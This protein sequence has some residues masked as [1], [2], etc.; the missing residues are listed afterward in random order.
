V[1]V[2]LA[3]WHGPFL[4]TV[5]TLNAVLHSRVDVSAQSAVSGLDMKESSSQLGKH[6]PDGTRMEWL[7]ARRS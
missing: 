5:H 6:P 2:R 1:A 4:Y 7:P 3:S